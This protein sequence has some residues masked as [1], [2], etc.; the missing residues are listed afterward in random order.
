MS[1]TLYISYTILDTV[2]VDDNLT[3]DEAMKIAEEI[4]EEKGFLDYTNDIIL[5]FVEE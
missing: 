3:D 5:N 1:K 4:A 2:T